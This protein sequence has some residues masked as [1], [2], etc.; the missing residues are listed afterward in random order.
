VARRVTQA[1][2]DLDETIRVI[3]S[4]IFSL[5]AHEMD[6]N[7]SSVRAEVIEIC[8]RTAAVLGFPPAVRF[9]GPVDTLVGGQVGEHLLAVLRE[10]LSNA[11]RHASASKVEV[12]VSAEARAITLTVTDNGAGMPEGGR[13]SGLTNLRERAEQLGGTFTAAPGLTGGTAVTWAVPLPG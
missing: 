6:Q 5:H 11:A 9:A 4:T 13:R 8:E 2:A 12:D 10:A 1:V 7:S 3:R